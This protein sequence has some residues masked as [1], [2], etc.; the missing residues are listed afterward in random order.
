MRCAGGY[1]EF[2]GIIALCTQGPPRR[3]IVAIDPVEALLDESRR[4]A[5]GEPDRGI[6]RQCRQG[7]AVEETPIAACGFKDPPAAT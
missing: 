3:D 2:A 7:L 6:A 4:Q 5:C 1:S